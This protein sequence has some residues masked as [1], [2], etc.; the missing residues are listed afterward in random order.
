MVFLL[1]YLKIMPRTASSTFE[2]ANTSGIS[3]TLTEGH[4]DQGPCSRNSA[5]QACYCTRNPNTPGCC[6]T[7]PCSIGTGLY[8]KPK[9]KPRGTGSSSSG[10]SSSGSSSG[11]GSSGSGSGSGTNVTPRD[12]INHFI[13]TGTNLTE[14]NTGTENNNTNTGNRRPMVRRARISKD[15]QPLVLGLGVLVLIVIAYKSI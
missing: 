1:Y 13:N 10:S 7:T 8:P 4:W 9:P 14:D 15:M 11:S 2:E 6:G 3:D 12:I 5:S